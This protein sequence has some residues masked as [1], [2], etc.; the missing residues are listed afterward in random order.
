MITKLQKHL[1][2]F[3]P[4]LL[5][6][7]SSCSEPPDIASEIQAA[8]KT[9]DEIQHLG[10]QSNNTSSSFLFD[11][12][13]DN[14]GDISI[15]DARLIVRSDAILRTDP[16]A[17]NQSSSLLEKSDLNITKTESY[18]SL[19]A[20]AKS[21]LKEKGKPVDL[22]LGQFERLSEKERISVRQEARSVI[23]QLTLDYEIA[24]TDQSLLRMMEADVKL[25]AI[26]SDLKKTLPKDATIPTEALALAPKQQIESALQGIKTHKRRIQE[27]VAI[28]GD[29]NNKA[30]QNYLSEHIARL[31]NTLHSNEYAAFEKQGN[32]T[33][34]E[35]S[36]REWEQLALNR[37]QEHFVQRKRILALAE[38]QT[39][40]LEIRKV[41]EGIRGPPLGLGKMVFTS[42]REFDLD[43]SSWTRNEARLFALAD[44]LYDKSSIPKAYRK[45][46]SSPFLRIV[47]L[48][49]DVSLER[50]K[51]SVGMLLNESIPEPALQILFPEKRQ[52]L[53]EWKMAIFQETERRNKGEPIVKF[54]NSE[55]LKKLLVRYTESKSEWPSKRTEAHFLNV[56]E[57]RFKK[58]DLIPTGLRNEVREVLT[59]SANEYA[60]KASE[61]FD[62]YKEVSQKLGASTDTVSKDLIKKHRETKKAILVVAVL[63][64][65]I[66][67][68]AENYGADVGEAK[69]KY[70]L[71]AS[72][73]S[74]PPPD[75]EIP[76]DPVP[77]SKPKPSSPNGGS[78]QL[79]LTPLDLDRLQ[80]PSR[81]RR[82]HPKL[83]KQLYLIQARLDNLG[84][85]LKATKSSALQLSEEP[86]K[87]ATDKG[88][89]TASKAEI[90]RTRLNYKKLEID[91]T[92]TRLFERHAKWAG[93]LQEDGT[94]F[95]FQTSVKNPTK[96]EALGGGIHLGEIAE[97][98]D[99]KDLSSAALIYHRK[100]GL[101][102]RDGKSGREWVVDKTLDP[103]ALKAL[104]RF[105]RSGRNAAIS[106]GWGTERL[107]ALANFQ[108]M[109][110]RESAVLLDPYLVDTAI[111]QDLIVADTIPW[112]LGEEKLPNGK[113]ISFS[114]RFR[115]LR[116]SYSM[117]D[118]KR[119]INLISPIRP[120]DQTN[121]TYWDKRLDQKKNWWPLLTLLQH[122]KLNEKAKRSFV[123]N[124][125]LALLR[126]E[127][128]S[129][130]N[131][132]NPIEDLRLHAAN[133]AKFE[134]DFQSEFEEFRQ[135]VK[136]LPMKSPADYVIDQHL[137]LALSEQ[138]N[139]RPMIELWCAWKKKTG[140]SMEQ[141]AAELHAFTNLT[142]LAVLYDD[143]VQF[144]LKRN[145]V[146]FSSQLKYL[147]ATS[148]LE[149]LDDYI[150]KGAAPEDPKNEV[151]RIG[152]LSDLVNANLSQLIKSFPPLKRVERY[153]AITAFLRWS[154]KAVK[155]GRLGLIDLSELGPYSANDRDKY[156]TVDVLIRN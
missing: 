14:S 27:I 11:S 24:A 4:F 56:L 1:R 141:I 50:A 147:Y 145:H 89:I 109:L 122:G 61:L 135:A 17:S 108:R 54:R 9:L 124:K 153:A 127:G 29:I 93:R 130:L 154:E 37:N 13:D 2:F 105:A 114:N 96:F 116:S 90:K 77:P 155:D 102:I 118:K 8:G 62:R 106:I 134:K 21:K 85:Q 28:G 46:E 120:F 100:K 103:R 19:L 32:N 123:D 98:S 42:I 39:G 86:I 121:L 47:S 94:P 23:N 38:A 104:F 5:L 57:N 3:L 53:E 75:G 112:E 87:F 41:S 156:P 70:F 51:M 113:P 48:L 137:L 144:Q 45:P 35:M 132:K 136:S 119:L 152:P 131:P 69:D 59:R 30:I 10:D 26:Q 101:M 88:R 149:I 129:V 107:S 43:P 92:T 150:G 91:K 64:N 117:A 97:Y 142:T 125:I 133:S 111:G 12:D 55:Y 40:W 71:L 44:E 65:Q 146:E 83:D 72:L 20:S 25:A 148:Y 66:L 63:L 74:R 49:N 82:Y 58:Q 143:S 34:K 7:L 140:Y 110:R 78:G 115:I 33:F 79:K 60:S 22:D 95:P 67:E 36:K 81:F 80:E 151:N 128:I 31:E 52:H 138:D 126:R 18:K 139:N 99:D 73:G 76:T 15:A 84:E 16:I 6:C 68:K